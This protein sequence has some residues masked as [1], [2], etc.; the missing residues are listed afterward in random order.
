MNFG[1]VVVWEN[2][3]F[4]NGT[5][6]DKIGVCLNRPADDTPAVLAF[7]TSKVGRFA[8][9][10]GCSVD[11]HFFFVRR[12]PSLFSTDT[13]ILLQK[14]YLEPLASIQ[15]MRN[16][17]TMRS[18]FQLKPNQANELRNCVLRS[19]DISMKILKLLK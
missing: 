13:W 6:R 16:A 8:A 15:R 12:T 5:I 4:P 3:L 2:Y 11:P 17:G 10:P 19:E 9:T 14:V 1:E 7:T 18:I